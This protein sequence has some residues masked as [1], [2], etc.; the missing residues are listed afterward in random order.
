MRTC[1]PDHTD[2]WNTFQEKKAG[3]QAYFIY[4][5]SITFVYLVLAAL[6][7][8]RSSPAA[9]V[10]VVPFVP[11]LFVAVERLSERRKCPESSP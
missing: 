3:S 5:I 7:E 11:V 2:P 10:L 6:Y 4:A 1:L 9:A 8:S